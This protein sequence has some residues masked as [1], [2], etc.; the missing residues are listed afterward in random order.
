M[1]RKERE[2][3]KPPSKAYL[4]SFGDTMT[5][6]LAFFIVLNSL[7]EEQTGANLHAGTG[8]FVQALQSGGL[9]GGSTTHSRRAVQHN[10]TGPQYIPEHDKKEDGS[11]P[12]QGADPE[13]NGVRSMDRELED[14]QRFI[15]EMDRIAK[16]KQLPDTE[17]EVQ[18]DFFE[19]LEPEPP[20]LGPKYRTLIRQV[21]PLLRSGRY[22]VEV[23]VWATM[24]SASAWSRSVIQAD[25]VAA[26]LRKRGGLN[27]KEQQRL[28]AISQPWGFSDVRRPVVSVVVRKLEAATGNTQ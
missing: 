17:G 24:P 8:S 13:S 11:P 19:S 6:L 16:M 21:I 20:L 1:A 27:A 25:G 18:F 3:D 7:A 9:P 28:S 4:V 26:E 5:T 23:I 2:P 22:Q 10:E 12:G 15:N 14:F